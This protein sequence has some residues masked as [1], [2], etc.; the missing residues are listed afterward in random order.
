MET[1]FVFQSHWPPPPGDADR[2]PTEIHSIVN[3]YE[4]PAEQRSPTLRK[5]RSYRYIAM[6]LAGFAAI[7]GY[8]YLTP[9]MTSPIATWGWQNWCFGFA[10]AAY[11]VFAATLAVLVEWYAKPIALRLL[12]VVL[13]PLLFVTGLIGFVFYIDSANIFTG[14]YIL[15]GLLCPVV[16]IYFALS[17]HR[18][19][20]LIHNG[21]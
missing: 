4:S 8:I 7:I 5:I 10:P 17:V 18:S 19:S 16:W 21:G 2:Y 6:L 20:A 14:V 15:L 12:P 9:F 13:F 1:N 11:L 3:P